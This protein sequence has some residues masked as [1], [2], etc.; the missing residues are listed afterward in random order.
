MTGLRIHNR[1]DAGRAGQER[2]AGLRL[3]VSTDGAAW[4][5]VWTAESVEPVWEVQVTDYRAGAHVPGR[6][7]RYLRLDLR[8]AQPEYFHLRKVE[9]WA[10]VAE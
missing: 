9:V 8:P 4:Q 10:K 3:S 5:D 2:A 7:A 6:A 1:T